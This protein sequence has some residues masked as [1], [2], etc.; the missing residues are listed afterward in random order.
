MTMSICY[1]NDVGFAAIPGAKR[2]KLLRT[3]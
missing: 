3:P 1:E 2:P